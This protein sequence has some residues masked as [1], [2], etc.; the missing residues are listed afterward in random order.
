M[1]DYTKLLETQRGPFTVIVDK[2]WEDIPLEHCFDDGIDPDTGEVYFNFKEMYAKI[3]RGD[4]DW[5]MMRTRVLLD[6][7]ELASE[8]LGGMLYEDATEALTDGTAEDQIAQALDSAQAEAA[9]LF[10]KLQRL[11]EQLV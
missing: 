10:A 5:F 9:Q 6:G 3:E 8:Y 4:L 1:R 11:Q 2:T 7:Y